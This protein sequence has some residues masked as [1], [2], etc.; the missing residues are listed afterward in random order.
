MINFHIKLYIL[1]LSIRGKK[2]FTDTQEN[3]KKT[4]VI[5]STKYNKIGLNKIFPSLIINNSL[6][7]N[8]YKS[9]K[10]RVNFFISASPSI[11]MVTL[12]ENWQI[13]NFYGW[14]LFLQIRWNNKKKISIFSK[15]KKASKMFDILMTGHWK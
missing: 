9:K 12:S 4:W 5:I 3:I 7:W 6:Q 15:K 1:D 11:W 2:F 14:R 13:I 8:I 10:G